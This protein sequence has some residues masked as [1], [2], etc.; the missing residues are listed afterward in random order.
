[1]AKVASLIKFKKCKFFYL[2]TWAYLVALV[3]KFMSPLE[4]RR[5]TRTWIDTWV[6]KILWRR[7]W[8][9]TPVFLPG[10]LHVQESLAVYSPQG[11][12]EPDRTE[13]TFCC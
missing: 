5:H 2:T 13:V 9:P 10:E 12:K 7:A 8:Q 11:C 6:R 1:M 4:Y 3:A